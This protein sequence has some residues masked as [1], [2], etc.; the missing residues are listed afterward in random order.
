MFKKLVVFKQIFSL[1][2]VNFL[3]FPGIRRLLL[4]RL[5]ISY[6]KLKITLIKDYLL[7]LNLLFAV[8]KLKTYRKIFNLRVT[9]FDEFLNKDRH[10]LYNKNRI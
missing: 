1:S 9:L 5:H 2:K 10:T 4:I 3:K 6:V 8:I 7:R